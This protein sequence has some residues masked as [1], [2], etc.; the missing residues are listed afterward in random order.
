[1]NRKA[2]Q[3]IQRF[4][5]VLDTF[6]LYPQ[7]NGPVGETESGETWASPDS[8]DIFSQFISE[9]TDDFIFNSS[10]LNFLDTDFDGAGFDFTFH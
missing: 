3:C 5:Q 10:Q 9:P 6:E 7:D 1:M 4:L 8:N 2:R